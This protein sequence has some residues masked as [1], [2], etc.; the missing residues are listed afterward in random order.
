LQERSRDSACIAK[1][2][3]TG[4][5]ASGD[6]TTRV[7][8]TRRSNLPALD[9]GVVVERYFSGRWLVRFDGSDVLSFYSP[10]V[11]TINAKTFTYS[12]PPRSDSLQWTMGVGWRF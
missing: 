1:T 3:A 4:A 6:T 2:P 11:F 7:I 8:S 10:A 12:K 5:F 9:M